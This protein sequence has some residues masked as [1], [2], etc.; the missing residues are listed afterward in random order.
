M[1]IHTTHFHC[2]AQTI[3]NLWE[4][5]RVI[6]WKDSGVTCLSCCVHCK[7]S[8]CSVIN[9]LSVFIY[10]AVRSEV[11]RTNSLCALTLRPDLHFLTFLI[12]S[13]E[14]VLTQ[15]LASNTLAV[16]SDTLSTATVERR[17]MVSWEC[18]FLIYKSWRSCTSTTW[19]PGYL[20][21]YTFLYTVQFSR[22]EWMDFILLNAHECKHVIPR[23]YEWKFLDLVC[24]CKSM[25]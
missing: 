1:S 18:V 14:A 8:I 6:F 2:L 5:R 11:K 9:V 19:V 24:W 20:S 15:A 25:V 16:V 23:W 21:D 13:V 3:R 12:P 10:P 7:H 4:I 22:A 17:V